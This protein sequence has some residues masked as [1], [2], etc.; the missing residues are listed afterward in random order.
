MPTTAQQV[1]DWNVLAASFA[2]A[3][4]DSDDAPVDTIMGTPWNLFEKLGY[5]PLTLAEI[6]AS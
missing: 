1:T 5:D 4:I 3:N 2:L 6:R